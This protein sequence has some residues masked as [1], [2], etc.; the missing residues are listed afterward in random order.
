LSS[1][2]PL[3]HSFRALNLLGTSE[4]LGPGQVRVILTKLKAGHGRALG[5][6]PTTEVV[7]T[8]DAGLED[9]QVLQA[10]GSKALRRVRLQRLLDEALNQGA[11]AVQDD[12]AQALHV[13][14]RNPDFRAGGVFA[15]PRLL[16]QPDC[17]GEVLAAQSEE[18]GKRSPGGWAPMAL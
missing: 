3:C 11:T 15:S 18:A 12:L 5:D 9:R 1:F 16:R 4:H 13:S 8:V 17:P 7:W 2:A 6:T 14:V 10:H